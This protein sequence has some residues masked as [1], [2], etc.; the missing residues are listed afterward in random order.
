VLVFCRFQ[1]ASVKPRWY[2]QSCIRLCMANRFAVAAST[3]ACCGEA[4]DAGS[5]LVVFHW[6]VNGYTYSR[7]SRGVAGTCGDVASQKRTDSAELPR[8]V[9]DGVPVAGSTSHALPVAGS[10]TTRSQ[11]SAAAAHH[12]CRVSA[13]VAGGVAG[14]TFQ[15]GLSSAKLTR[16]SRTSTLPVR[17]ST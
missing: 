9:N 16:F 8:V 7:S 10:V 17:A 6:L 4:S 1:V 12:S 5:H 13:P 11:P 3:S 15:R 2:D 14:K